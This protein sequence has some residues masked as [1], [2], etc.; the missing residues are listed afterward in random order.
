MERSEKI[1]A[2]PVVKWAGGKRKL[3]ET[4]LRY[5]PD[6]NSYNQYFEPFAGGA[7]VFFLLQPKNSTLID[8]NEDL[9]NVYLTIKQNVELL[10][11]DLKTHIHTSD[12]FYEIRSKDT[13]HMD[14][15]QRASRTIYLNKT[16]FNGLYRVNSK[17]QFNVPFGKYKNPMICDEKNLRNVSVLLQDVTLISGSYN[18]VKKLAKPKDFVYFDPPYYPLNQTSNFT[19]YT[20]GDFKPEDQIELRDL[21][22]ELCNK[23]VYCALSNSSSEFIIDLYKEFKIERIMAARAINSDATKRSKIEEILVLGGFK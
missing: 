20:K 21:F 23:G 12:Y 11:K 17:N 16:C 5:F 8:I 22:K 4:F 6:S 15:V 3:V 2:N 13:S 7:A 18:L 10:I 19:S 1:N 14:T 9:I